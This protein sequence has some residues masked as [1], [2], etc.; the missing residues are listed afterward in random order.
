M[1]KKISWI[2]TILLILSCLIACQSNTSTVDYQASPVSSEA[3]T[4]DIQSS[5]FKIGYLTERRGDNASNDAYFSGVQ[6]FIDETGIE[7]TVI[8]PSELQDYEVNARAFCQENY[9][10]IIVLHNAASE[11]MISL[12]Q[13]YPNT[14]FYLNDTETEGIA[15]IT[16]RRARTNEAGFLTG[17]FNVL[18]NQELGGDAKSAFIGGMRNPSLERSQYSFTSGSEYVGGECTVVYVGNFTDIAKGKEIALQ[19]YQDGFM[20]MQAFAGGAGTGV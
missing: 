10:L 5:V 8:E 2:F 11:M 6:R 1:K 15:N 17:A 20:L 12:A 3:A 9:D 4:A 19:L 13:E 18:M 16:G 7:I 14:H